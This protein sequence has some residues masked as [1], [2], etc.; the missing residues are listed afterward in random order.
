MVKVP[1]GKEVEINLWDSKKKHGMVKYFTDTMDLVRA[2]SEFSLKKGD[3]AIVVESYDSFV[4]VVPEDEYTQL[5]HGSHLDGIDI[6]GLNELIYK[7]LKERIKDTGGILSFDELWSIFKRSSIQSVITKKHLKK[8]IKIRQSSFDRI[9]D[10]GDTIV[11][12]KPQECLND[13]TQIVRHS[14]NTSYVTKDFLQSTLH[15]SDLRIERILDYLT[16][17]GR[18]RVEDSFRTGTRYYMKFS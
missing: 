16:K 9:K 6:Q 10:D 14:S 7:L 15:W 5:L 2:E 3:S 18:C 12:L 11:A 8:A 17:E 4:V 13:I 1:I